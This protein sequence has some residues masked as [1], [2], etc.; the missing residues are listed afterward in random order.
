MAGIKEY[1]SNRTDVSGA[2]SAWLKANQEYQLA[3]QRFDATSQ[4]SK[5][6]AAVTAALKAAKDKADAA[7]AKRKEVR[8]AAT[9]EYEK[10][11]APKKAKAE[12][13]RKAPIE[14][15]ISVIQGQIAKAEAGGLDTTQL[16]NDLAAAQAKLTPKAA[17]VDTSGTGGT[18]S[19][20][21]TGATGPVETYSQLIS[22]LSDPTKAAELKGFQQQLNKLGSNWAVNANGFWSVDFQD[23][24][25][26]L[27]QA[28]AILPA[29]YQGADINE[30]ITIAQKNPELIG[31]TGTGGA[32]GAG[33][34]KYTPTA[35]ISAPTEASNI[36][37]NTFNSVLDRTASAKEVKQLTA[38]LNK[39]Q[40][41]NPQTPVLVN[42][43]LQYKGGLNAAQWLADKLMA[44][45]EYKTS[46]KAKTDLGLQQL[47]QTA[48]A[49][50][51]DLETNF[52]SQLPGWSE[53]IA[54]GK[55]IAEFQTLIRSAARAHLPESVK[56]SIDPSLDLSVAYSPYINSYARTFGV[57]PRNVKIS[58]IEKLALT[59]KGLEPIYKFDAKKKALPQWQF[60]PEAKDEVS[61]GINQVLQDF[62]F[63][64]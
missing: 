3:K 50:G 62:G 39:A 36:I 8:A 45:E 9:A 41:A 25:Q 5:N 15:E 64:G 57:D 31:S 18:G 44:S 52:A 47:R 53:A 61:A 27:Y 1:L 51:L 59:D 55:P 43:V 28:R 21:G 12:A 2:D 33:T 16:K 48:T 20:G 58:D 60:T 24:L 26:K 34:N 46:T 63:V 54:A 29:G 17:T 56:N 11:Q 4:D 38:Q 22:R 35:N 10:A 40:A 37:Q 49:N 19:T 42:G 6:F 14:R 23:K 7:D 32:G 13:G 30:F